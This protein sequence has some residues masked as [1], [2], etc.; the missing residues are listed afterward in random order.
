MDI[1]SQQRSFQNVLQELSKFTYGLRLGDWIVIILMVQQL[2]HT[3][4][5]ADSGGSQTQIPI[6]CTLPHKIRVTSR[7]RPRR[8]ETLEKGFWRRYE[9]LL[10]FAW[11]KNTDFLIPSRTTTLSSVGPHNQTSQNA[12]QRGSREWQSRFALKTMVANMDGYDPEY[13]AAFPK[14]KLKLPSHSA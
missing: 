8:Q 14:E 1:F 13:L 4:G 11:K 5:M 9:L 3:M 12:S 10:K 2:W 7:H 6:S